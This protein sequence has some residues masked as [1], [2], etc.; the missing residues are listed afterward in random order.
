MNLREIV[1]AIKAETDPEKQKQLLEQHEAK[2]KELTENAEVGAS[3]KDK[4]IFKQLKEAQD[5]LAEVERQRKEDEDK[6]KKEQGEYKE[7]AETKGKELD[8]LKA[9]FE[10]EK[11]E[12]DAYRTYKET[13][14]KE[15]IDKLSDEDK[16]IANEIKDLAKLEKYVAKQLVN[17]PTGT[18]EGGKPKPPEDDKELTPDE[19]KKAKEMFNGAD[20]PIKEYKLF[21]KTYKEKGK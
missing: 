1:D 3:V 18:D 9:K 8:E 14:R 15:L 11:A 21:K 10:K 5:K 16:E 12:A 17:P 2:L 13:K 20:D 4:G 19:I 6:R 7:L